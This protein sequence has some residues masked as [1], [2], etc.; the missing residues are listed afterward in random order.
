MA[1]S[2]V[3]HQIAHHPPEQDQGLW[4][5]TEPCVDGKVPQEGPV[6]VPR[7][8]EELEHEPVD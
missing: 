1:S 7:S 3:G 2:S 5:S 4:S 6:M 8:G